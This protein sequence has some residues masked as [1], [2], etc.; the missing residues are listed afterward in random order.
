MTAKT[1]ITILCGYFLCCCF[2]VFWLF[3][4]VNAMRVVYILLEMVIPN[5]Q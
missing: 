3:T 2:L 4:L 5:M 1:A